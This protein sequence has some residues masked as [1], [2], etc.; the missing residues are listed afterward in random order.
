M[1][2]LHELITKDNGKFEIPTEFNKDGVETLTGLIP[3]E[4]AITKSKNKMF[5]FFGEKEKMVNSLGKPLYK[6]ENALRYL[7]D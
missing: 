2:K 4:T 3:Y 1:S 6:S 5:S 7:L